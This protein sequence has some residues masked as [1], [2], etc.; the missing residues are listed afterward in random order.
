M[1]FTCDDIN[2]TYD[3]LTAHGVECPDPP[4]QQSW[5][6]SAT[7]KDNEGNLSGLGQRSPA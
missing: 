1:L 4:S 2:K 3:E 6:W 5:G 7:F